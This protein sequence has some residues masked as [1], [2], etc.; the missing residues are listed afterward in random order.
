MAGLAANKNPATL[1]KASLMITDHPRITCLQE[2]EL[3]RQCIIQIMKLD[4]VSKQ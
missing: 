2:I 4:S 3:N 1:A